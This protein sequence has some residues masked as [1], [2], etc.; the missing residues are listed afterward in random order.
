MRGF[1]PNKISNASLLQAT[2]QEAMRTILR[3]RW[4]WLRHVLRME[5]TART[6]MT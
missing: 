6:A 3:Q 1:W 4:K 2:R 5:P